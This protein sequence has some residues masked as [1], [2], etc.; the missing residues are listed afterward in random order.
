MTEDI[1]QLGDG[2]LGVVVGTA[3]LLNG[4]TSHLVLGTQFA[5]FLASDFRIRATVAVI[6]GVVTVFVFV[7]IF[8]F[9]FVGEV[10]L[11]ELGADMSGGRRHVIHFVRID[12]AGD[13]VGQA[14][15]LGFVL[16]VLFEQIGDGFRVLGDGALYLVD[17]VFDP[18]GDVDLAFAGQQFDGTHFPH[19]H[20]DGIGRATNLRFNRCQSLGRCFGSVLIGGTTFSHD[21]V[22]GIRSVFNHLNAHIVD[23]LD[24]VFDLV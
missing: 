10:V 17:T 8:V 16:V 21:K 18:L 9:V 20:A 12:E 5:E 19:V 4:E 2:I 1:G 11:A 6:V 22:I 3:I 7:L 13:D 14:K 15:L 23:H 24:D